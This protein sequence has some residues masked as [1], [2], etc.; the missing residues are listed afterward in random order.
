MTHWGSLV[1]AFEIGKGRVHN[2]G[3]RI[4]NEGDQ[5]DMSARKFLRDM[6]TV[7]ALVSLLT[8]ST[9]A[10]GEKYEFG[11]DSSRQE[12]VPEGTVTKLTWDGSKVYPDTEHEYW[13]YV[14]AQYTEDEPACVMVFQDG[15]SYVSE[16]GSVRA[17]IVFDN[18]T[19]GFLLALVASKSVLR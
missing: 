11:Q 19:F 10:V 17:S 16:E 18:L 15:G 6:S 8:L 12:G 3:R 5:I 1:T 13:V 14:P 9:G 7:L 4:F 2:G